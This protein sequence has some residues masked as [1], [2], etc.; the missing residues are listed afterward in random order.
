SALDKQNCKSIIESVWDA[1][2]LPK[3]ISSLIYERT[4]GNPF[5]VEEISSALIEEGK[6]QIKDQKAEL[7]QSQTN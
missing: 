5:F 6:V 4:G 7:T 3:G 1:E 2:H